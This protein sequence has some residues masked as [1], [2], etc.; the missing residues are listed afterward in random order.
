[1]RRRTSAGPLKAKNLPF[2]TCSDF[3][4]DRQLKISGLGMCF[5]SLFHHHLVHV[6]E[7]RLVV[8]E[9]CNEYIS[10]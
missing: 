6:T 1:M 7:D 10:E 8:V 9:V 3:A 5:I 4:K 2:T